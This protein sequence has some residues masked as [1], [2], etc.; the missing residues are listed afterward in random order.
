V[1]VLSWVSRLVDALI[2]WWLGLKV[3]S[4]RSGIRIRLAWCGGDGSDPSLH[5]WL[6]RGENDLPS[7]AADSVHGRLACK[8]V[9]CCL[10][11]VK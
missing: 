11:V 2:S 10:F 6:R 8:N 1:V 4:P 5:N 7:R 9:H 3:N